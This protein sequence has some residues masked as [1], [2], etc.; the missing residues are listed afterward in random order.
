[1]RSYVSDSA[2]T[3]A[4]T[5]EV[6]W[7]LP[8]PLATATIAWFRRLPTSTETRDDSYLLAPWLDGLSVK[9][10]SGA[11]FDVKVYR[12]SAGVF[13][14]PGHARGRLESWQK[15][16]FPFGRES[17]RASGTPGWR[18][19]RKVRRLSWFTM[20]G[21][22]LSR[23]VGLQDDAR[24][25][26]ELTEIVTVGTTSWTLAFEAIGPPERRRETLEAAAA[27]VF[28]EPLPSGFQLRVE[29]SGSYADWLRARWA[30]A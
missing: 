30:G 16:S 29:D 7:I 21:D 5:L 6:R 11:T 26:V 24:C 20:P 28:A 3:G 18:Q 14:V 15:V 8:G 22:W 4:P 23:P 17:E 10:R 25:A 12:G 27:F 1:V 13:E 19:V 9:I 2:L